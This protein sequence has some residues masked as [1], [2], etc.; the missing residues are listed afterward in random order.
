MLLNCDLGEISL[1]HDQHIMPFID[2]ANIACGVHAGDETSMEETIELASK[3]NVAI[4]AHPSYPDR[5]N[6]GRVSMALTPE[7]LQKTFSSQVKAII[8][9][10]RK[11]QT[12]CHYVKPHGAL[13]NDMM[14]NIELFTRICH[15]MSKEFPATSLMV[16]ALP[17]I[18]IF[19]G[20]ADQFNVKLL[21][22]AFADRRY[23]SSGL[24][25][26]R[27][28][29]GAVIEDKASILEQVKAL[30]EQNTVMT[31]DRQAI[32][33]TADTLCV[34]GDSQHALAWVKQIRQ[35]LNEPS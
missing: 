11:H 26:P 25:V 35:Y 28:E 18:A 10:C 23:L 12:V 6:F 21:L 5:E 13:Y 3:H 24:L 32:R 15:I 22:E 16:Q 20:I 2:Q 34:H 8:S 19:Q 31:I 14:K 33:I 4:G 17:N 9:Y 7:Q 30:C 27:K 29:K 1:A